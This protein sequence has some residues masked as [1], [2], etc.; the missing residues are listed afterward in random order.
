M[1]E[2][3]RVKFESIRKLLLEVRPAL[4]WRWYCNKRSHAPKLQ[5]VTP[6]GVVWDFKLSG[7]AWIRKSAL[8]LKEPP[9]EPH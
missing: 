4:R 8:T 5:L 9:H 6:R 3:R 2:W 1:P 7:G